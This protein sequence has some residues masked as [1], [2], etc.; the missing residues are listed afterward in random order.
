MS[1]ARKP[2][3]G[4]SDPMAE[5][6][7]PRQARRSQ[8]WRR[9]IAVA[10]ALGAAVA[11]VALTHGA[12]AA[13]NDSRTSTATVAAGAVTL[14]WNATGTNQLS[15]P[16]QGLVPGGTAQHLVDLKNTG[17]VNLSALQLSFSGT[18]GSL[19]TDASDG[20]QLQIRSCSA[21]W[22]GSSGS[23]AC[24]GTAVTVAP[25]GSTLADRPVSGRTDFTASPDF[26]AGGVDHL[27][28]TFRLPTSSPTA[29][30]GATGTVSFTVLGIQ[31]P[32]TQK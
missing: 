19:T 8:P 22:T 10:A 16:I 5:P 29:A 7:T 9:S 32:G 20:L 2:R 25:A 31:R 27:L 23:Y 18:T 21:A 3:S 14:N 26:T 30:Q 1:A 12:Y 17:S 4:S 11:L 28:M 13:F 24:P 6:L 15:I